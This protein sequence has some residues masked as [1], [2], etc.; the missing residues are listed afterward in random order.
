MLSADGLFWRLTM[1]EEAE[2]FC[3]VCSTHFSSFETLRK[4]EAAFH[5]KTEVQKTA[6]PLCPP[7]RSDEIDPETNLEVGPVL[8]LLTDEQKD[9]LLLRALQREPTLAHEM[10]DVVTAPL[11]P[12]AAAGRVEDLKG[13]AATQAV[14]AY[15]ELDAA[16][17]ALTMLTA[18]TE[19]VVDALAELAE[20]L[21]G[22]GRGGAS[23]GGGA[24]DDEPDWQSSEA[25][26]AVEAMPAAGS[27]AALWSK[28]LARAD[29]RRLV[30]EE[31]AE[32]LDA[33]HE[34]AASVRRAAPAVLVGADGAVAEFDEPIKLLRRAL[35]APTLAQ[36]EK[37]S[38]KKKKKARA[39]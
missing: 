5:G 16:A 3:T 1:A 33:A 2:P 10:L 37:E 21:P 36:A 34:A 22:P 14:R 18:V 28:L 12:E 29:V 17:N 26:R 20:L 6:E 8:A 7:A 27:V 23:G 9:M 24:V 38:G 35:D 19:A 11:T 39:F 25:M 4:H 31:I 15:M 30:D 13:E 32:I